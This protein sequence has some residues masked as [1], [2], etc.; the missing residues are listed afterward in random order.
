[1]VVAPVAGAA[2]FVVFRRFHVGEFFSVCL[3][4]R[5]F[6]LCISSFG[7]RLFR[8]YPVSHEIFSLFGLGQRDRLFGK[9]IDLNLKKKKNPP[10]KTPFL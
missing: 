3:F 9:E 8:I 5:F 6:G 10:N 1:M 2:F 4:V 7:S